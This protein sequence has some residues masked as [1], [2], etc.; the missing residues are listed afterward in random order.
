MMRSVATLEDNIQQQHLPWLYRFS[1]LALEDSTSG[2]QAHSHTQPVR[3][4]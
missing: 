1:F 4:R 3:S 2:L